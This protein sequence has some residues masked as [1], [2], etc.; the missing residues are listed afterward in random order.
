MSWDC[1]EEEKKEAKE[2]WLA[3]ALVHEWWCINM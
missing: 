3:G 2:E 1:F